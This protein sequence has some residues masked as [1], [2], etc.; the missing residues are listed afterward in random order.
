MQNFSSFNFTVYTGFMIFVD[1][2]YSFI[3]FVVHYVTVQDTF[4]SYQ[5][6]SKSPKPRTNLDHEIFAPSYTV[7]IKP[8]FDK[9]S[10]HCSWV[11]IS[12]FK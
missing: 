11:L 1:F 9:S 12:T 10:F 2:S 6:G 4:N 5:T 3:F 7:P 8:S